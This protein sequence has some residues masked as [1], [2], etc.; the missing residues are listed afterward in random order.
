MAEALVQPIASE[1]VATV[2]ART[3]TGSPVG[4]I[5]IAGPEVLSIQEFVKRTLTAD[6]DARIVAT[7]AD[8][9]YFGALIAERTLLP[10]DD[11]Q[12]SEARLDEW[13][14]A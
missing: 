7:A 12:L 5:E 3:A 1:D 2:V 11:A 13:L 4:D 10:E 8:A 9:P 14:S 6:G